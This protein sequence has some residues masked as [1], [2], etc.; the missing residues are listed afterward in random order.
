MSSILPESFTQADCGRAGCSTCQGMGVVWIL[1]FGYDEWKPE[2]WRR[3]HCP[4]CTTAQILGT[5]PF[6]T[7]AS[8]DR[9]RAA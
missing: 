8:R 6:R 3:E 9:R 4:S 2:T 7:Q 1:P 5:L